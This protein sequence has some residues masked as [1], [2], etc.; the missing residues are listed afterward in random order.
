VIESVTAQ[1]S[2]FLEEMEEA[3]EKERLMYVAMTRAQDKLICCAVHDGTVSESRDSWID[4]LLLADAEA[5]GDRFSLSFVDDS[6]LP[7]GPSA[8][9]RARP[10]NTAAP[11]LAKAE[12]YG[13]SLARISATAY[14][15]FMWCP[16]AYRMRY[17]QG[18]NLKWELPDGDGY[19]GADLGSF[20]HW[21]LARWNM[22][23]AGMDRLLPPGDL[24]YDIGERIKRT[25]PAFLR[26]I[27]ASKRDREILRSWLESFSATDECARLRELAERGALRRELAFLV[28]FEGA[29]LV[30]SM[31]LYWEDKRGGHVRDWKI[32][33]VDRAPEEL[34]REQVNFYALV[35]RIAS[36]DDDAQE[37]PIDAGL[38][39]LRPSASR[40]PVSEGWD[41]GDLKDTEDNVKRVIEI[42][43]SGPF[44]PNK[45]RCR[46]CPFRAFCNK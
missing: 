42:A 16:V 18:R 9:D 13:V 19:G 4:W 36:R 23:L 32:T 41:A 43:A 38:I 30:G 24:P 37:K 45:D 5:E 25:L 10:K 14:S 29:N 11:K 7:E 22:K 35:C 31:D 34:Y 12:R 46:R 40:G 15:L 2:R 17:R 44:E 27:F 39:Y 26:P 8:H 6:K 3:E 1:W 21:A 20:A 28:P 33:L